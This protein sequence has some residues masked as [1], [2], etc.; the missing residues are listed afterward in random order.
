MVA[1]L[2]VA[3]LLNP[4]SAMAGSKRRVAILPFEFGSV[5]SNVGTLDVGKGITSLIITKLVNDGTYSVVERQTLDAILKEQNLSNSD[6][7]N[8]ATAAKIGKLL[9]ADAIIVGTV[10]QFGFENKHVNVGAAAAAGMSY[11]PYVGGLG[12]FGFGGLGVKKGKVKVAIDARLVDINTGEILAA[13]HGT[14]ESKRSG[15][16]LFGG[17]GGGGGAGSGSFDMG[18]SDF[19]SSIAGEA[20]L[21]AVGDICGQILSNSDKIPDNQSVAQQNVQGK[22]ADVTGNSVTV[23]VG[24]LNGL[25]VGDSLQVEHPVKTIRD[26]D[27]GKVIKEVTN[28][29]AVVTL[30][31]VDDT[32]ASGTIIRGSSPAIGDLVRKVTTDVSAVMLSAGDSANNS[33]SEA[34]T[35]PSQPANK[36]SVPA[37]S[38]AKT[39]AKQSSTAK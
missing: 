15:V 17:G 33:K 10:T 26:P 3:S 16:S 27:T 23:N 38:A 1:L 34:T 7:A 39:S 13:V 8:P 32:T 21:A 24:K 29:V 25:S 36:T 6:R 2:I 28:T 19:A 9:G 31:Q 14:G 22:I 5:T 37:Q 35:T 18:S 11:V 30:N 12:G 4:F 20:T